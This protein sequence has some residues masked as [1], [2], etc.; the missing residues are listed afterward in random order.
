ML[1]HWVACMFWVIERDAF[2]GAV[3]AK[4]GTPITPD[5]PPEFSVSPTEGSMNRRSGDPIEVT[6]R[7]N[8][9]A[10]TEGMVATLV[11]ETEDFKKVYKFI[12][13]T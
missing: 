12:G 3:V 10:P 2:V 6:V 9:K 1:A 8:P 11:F 4:S 5:S 13:S 7:F